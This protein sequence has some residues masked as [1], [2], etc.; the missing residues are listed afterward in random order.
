MESHYSFLSSLLLPFFLCNKVK[1]TQSYTEYRQLGVGQ[2]KGNSQSAATAAL[3]KQ[4]KRSLWFSYTFVK[5]VSMF[6]HHIKKSLCLHKH[7]VLPFQIH[8]I[9]YVWLLPFAIWFCYYLDIKSSK[10]ENQT[11]VWIR[12]VTKNSNL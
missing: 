9:K 5:A 7:I 8:M 3:Q 4:T 6:S 10:F 12:Y 11:K 2:T 1:E